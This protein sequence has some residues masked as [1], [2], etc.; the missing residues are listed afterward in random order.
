MVEPLITTPNGI[1]TTDKQN[2]EVRG[3]LRSGAKKLE[4]TSNMVLKFFK[5]M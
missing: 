1:E 5:L 4:S 2:K 3:S